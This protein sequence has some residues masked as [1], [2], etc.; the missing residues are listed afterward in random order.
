MVADNSEVGQGDGA[1]A[2]GAL[3]ARRV[4][5]PRIKLD[6]LVIGINTFLASD[7]LWRSRHGE[8]HFKIRGLSKQ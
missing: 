8:R 1:V 5:Q 6:L 4:V 7:A 2:I 3:R